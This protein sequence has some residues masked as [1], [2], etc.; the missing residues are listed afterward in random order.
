MKYPSKGKKSYGEGSPK[1]PKKE[2]KTV[3]SGG[4]M[5]QPS[6]GKKTS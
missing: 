1:L 3:T 2:A 4:K 6:K 5:R